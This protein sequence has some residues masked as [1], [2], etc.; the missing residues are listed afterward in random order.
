MDTQIKKMA[1]NILSVLFF[2]QLCSVT[3][4]AQSVRYPALSE[5]TV[6]LQGDSAQWDSNKVHTFSI[7]EAN[8]DGYRYWG[9]YGLSYYGGDPTLRKAGLARSNDLVH[10]DKYEGN[11]IIQG[12]CRWPNVLI[13][14]S[15]FYMFYAEYDTENNSCI[16]MVTSKDGIGFGNK[17]VVVPRE[18]GKQNQNPFIYFDPK[19]GYFNLAYYSGIE[20]SKDTTKN[21]WRIKLKRSKDIATLKDAKATILLASRNILAAPSLALFDNRYYLLAESRIPGKWESKWVTL[22]FE[23]ARIGGKYRATGDAHPILSDDDACA[24]QYLF[25]GQLYI[26]YSH[27]LDSQASNWDLRMVRTHR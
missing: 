18:R 7:I 21:L 3:L 1:W 2:L 11:P 19:D 13:D 12:D 25:D 22:A 24:F 26:F 23:S 4:L 10:W 6:V 16:V 9:Y 8:R 14:H 20:R 15:M 17:E 5:N 27:C